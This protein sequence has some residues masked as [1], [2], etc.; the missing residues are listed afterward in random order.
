MRSP[1]LDL[2]HAFLSYQGQLKPQ[3]RKDLFCGSSS[4]L[5]FSELDRP[6]NLRCLSVPPTGCRYLLMCNCLSHQK[7]G[8][9]M[10]CP[11]QQLA[12]E[13]A[14]S[15]YP[16]SACGPALPIAPVIGDL[17]HVPCVYFLCLWLR[18]STVFKVK[19]AILQ[20]SS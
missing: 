3:L 6:S 9:P 10:L 18:L 5:S 17:C 19:D 15:E 13:L 2:Y 1:N 11:P 8:H 14:Y 16:R 20:G 7:E 12:L 4:H